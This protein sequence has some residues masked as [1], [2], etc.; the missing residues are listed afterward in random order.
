MAASGEFM[1]FEQFLA[2][3]H[4]EGRKP[5]RRGRPSPYSN[6]F[7]DWA[8][9]SVPEFANKSRSTQLKMAAVILALKILTDHEDEDFSHICGKGKD[10][11]EGILAELGRFQEQP[12]GE[13]E[14]PQ[15]DERRILEL[16][17]EICRRKMT[18][19]QA[20]AWLKAERNGG[21]PPADTHELANR[22]AKLIRDY[23]SN[24][25]TLTTEQLREALE[26]AAT[27]SDREQV[28]P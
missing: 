19:R 21:P 4:E 6:A 18:T 16:A 28:D 10:F 17:R 22:I 23:R 15:L 26:L 14:A 13:D 2:S 12:P 11:H 25:A 3:L 8:A 20:V 1:A 5:P 7:F 27:A 24:H 9:T